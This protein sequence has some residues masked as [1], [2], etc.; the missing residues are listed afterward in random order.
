MLPH[1]PVDVADPYERL[2]EVQARVQA[3]R[4]QHE[5]EAGA[6]LTSAAA[7]GPF[8]PVAW[9]IRLGLRLPQRQITTVTTNVPGPRTTLYALGREVTEMLPYVPIADRVRVGVAMFSYRD[10]LTFGLTGDYDTTPDLQLLADGISASMEE[11]LAL[12]RPTG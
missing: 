5:P 4:A 7:Y 8:M 11:L 6:S 2:L 3:L 12:A 10:T 9:G 1:L